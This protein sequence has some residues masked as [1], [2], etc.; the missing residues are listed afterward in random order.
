MSYTSEQAL[1][2]WETRRKNDP[3][4]E[5]AKR[6]AETRIKNCIPFG[7]TESALKQ[8]N[9]KRKNGTVYISAVKSA[10]T[11]RKNGMLCSSMKKAAETKR[12]NGTN[13]HTPETKKKFR[14]IKL[15]QIMNDGHWQSVGNNEKDLLD[16]QEMLFDIKIDRNFTVIG[17]RPDGYCKETNTIYEI[18]EARHLKSIEKD[19]QR[20]KEIQ[21]HLNYDFKIIWDLCEVESKKFLRK[22]HIQEYKNIIIW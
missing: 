15:N 8:W 14:I 13:R 17:Y 21:E 1:K 22:H 6:G 10:E 4:N 20:Q 18:Y 2:A 9:T 16:L 5:S 7:T 12:K 11:K 19:L 3:N